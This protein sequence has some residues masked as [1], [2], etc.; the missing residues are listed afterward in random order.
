MAFLGRFQAVWVDYDV[1]Y[2][3]YDVV[4]I[5]LP[6]PLLPCRGCFLFLCRI[7]VVLLSSFKNSVVNTHMI[8]TTNF[9]GIK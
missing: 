2:T 6:Y 9:T 4:Q 1:K 8:P 5:S 3:I 7:Q